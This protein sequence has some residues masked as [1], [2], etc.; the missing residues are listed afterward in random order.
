MT[1]TQRVQRAFPS[2]SPRALPS[3]L[4][5][6][7][8]TRHRYCQGEIIVTSSIHSNAQDILLILLPLKLKYFNI[9]LTRIT[10]FK[11]KQTELKTKKKYMGN[12]LTSRIYPYPLIYK[13]ILMC[14]KII[15]K[16]FFYHN[17][18]GSSKNPAIWTVAWGLK[19][20]WAGRLRFR[21]QDP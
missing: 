18:S 16:S 8:R 21:S 2:M 20:G 9:N 10:K 13:Q 5:R 15:F 17:Y 3:A 6:L 14:F 19:C 4:H 12:I 11:P 1:L 7:P